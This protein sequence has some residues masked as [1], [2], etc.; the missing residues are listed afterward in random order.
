MKEEP[1]QRRRFVTEC[2]GPV[3]TPCGHNSWDTVRIRRGLATLRCRLCQ[4]Q[5]KCKQNKVPHCKRFYDEGE[6]DGGCNAVH[7]H[8]FKQNL[9]ERLEIHGSSILENVPEAI[10]LALIREEWDLEY[11]SWSKNIPVK[12]TE[13]WSPLHP[14]FPSFAY[15]LCW[16]DT[17]EEAS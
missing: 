15:T 5:W 9:K 3:Q 7:V 6:C 10:A 11:G 13:L 8:Q 17:T 2:E 16:W 14:G 1:S 4:K 12:N